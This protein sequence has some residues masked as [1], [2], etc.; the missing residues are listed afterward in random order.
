MCSRKLR[1]NA[2]LALEV[3]ASRHLNICVSTST[4]IGSGNLA[5]RV[6]PTLTTAMPPCV[7]S[8]HGLNVG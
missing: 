8:L 5:E 1:L 4:P 2:V 7:M 3:V 6:P